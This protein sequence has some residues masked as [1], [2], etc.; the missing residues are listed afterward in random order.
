MVGGTI[1]T[2]VFLMQYMF[3]FPYMFARSL[4]DISK[5]YIVKVVAVNPNERGLVTNK[6]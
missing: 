1:T 3:Y 6:L 5:S 4:E 2:S